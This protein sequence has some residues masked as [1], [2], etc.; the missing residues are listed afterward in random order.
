VP[1]VFLMATVSHNRLALAS[2]RRIVTQLLFALF[3]VVVPVQHTC[4]LA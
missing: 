2:Q 1:S 3:I 4:R